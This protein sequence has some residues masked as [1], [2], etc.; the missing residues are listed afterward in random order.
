MYEETRLTIPEKRLSLKND[1]GGKI[2]NKN[3]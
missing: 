1:K 2:E 3:K